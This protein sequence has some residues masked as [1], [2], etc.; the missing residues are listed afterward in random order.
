MS[1]CGSH[2]HRYTPGSIVSINGSQREF[3]RQP[4]GQSLYF[5]INFIHK[6]QHQCRMMLRIILRENNRFPRATCN[7]WWTYM[8]TDITSCLVGIG[9]LEHRKIYDPKLICFEGKRENTD[10]QSSRVELE[11]WI[12]NLRMLRAVLCSK[13]YYI[14]QYHIW[15]IM[16]SN[17]TLYCIQ[18]VVSIRYT[19]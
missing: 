9:V 12:R 1:W 7:I 5:I 6:K 11:I 13:M 19:F 16:Q 2:M 17:L 10:E 8:E 18:V 4:D 15:N 14:M 3:M